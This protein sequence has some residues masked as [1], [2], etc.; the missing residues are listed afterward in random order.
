MIKKVQKREIFE[1][2]DDLMDD[3]YKIKTAPV[4]VATILNVIAWIFLVYYEFEKAIECG[5]KVARYSRE[6]KVYSVALRAHEC[7]GKAYLDTMESEKALIS[8]YNMLLAALY[9]NNKKTEFRAYDLLS[10]AYFNLGEVERS[11]FFHLKLMDG[12][13]EPAD[14]MTRK[15]YENMKEEYNK[16]RHHMDDSRPSSPD[17][18]YFEDL[19]L[20]GKDKLIQ[21]IENKK[22]LL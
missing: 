7:I 16:L 12:E 22:E 14:S 11:K 8:F 4:A 15:K 2:L 20:N 5:K 9:L 17:V 19:P 6:T 10:S 3:I 1:V 18:Q 13:L 21:M